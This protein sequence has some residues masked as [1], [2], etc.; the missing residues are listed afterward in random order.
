[1]KKVY[2]IIEEYCFDGSYETET[3]VCNSKQTA[4]E[5]YEKI[6]KNE[7]ENSWIRDAI[8]NDNPQFDLDEDDGY[9]YCYDNCNYDFTAIQIKEKEIL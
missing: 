3:T 7:K 8:N 9:F 1:M 2:V 5:V 6:V 4:L